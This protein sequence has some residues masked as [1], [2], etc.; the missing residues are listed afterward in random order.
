[1]PGSRRLGRCLGSVTLRNNYEV[2]EAANIP[3]TFIL[4]QYSK[5]QVFEELVSGKN[6]EMMYKL[7][8]GRIVT[9]DE[10]MMEIE[11]N[12]V[13]G[14]SFYS[15]QEWKRRYEIQDIL[16]VLCV[17]GLASVEKQGRGFIYWVRAG[18]SEKVTNK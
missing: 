7:L 12:P 18:L 1:M 9:I 8:K 5:S 16:I 2:Y 17:L 11:Q 14:L 15:Y 4:R 10:V 13:P 6:V 3:S